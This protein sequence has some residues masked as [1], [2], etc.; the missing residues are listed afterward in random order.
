MQRLIVNKLT[1]L[2]LASIITSI[3]LLEC[4]L[5]VKSLAYSSNSIRFNIYKISAS[6]RWGTCFFR[7]RYLVGVA[8]PL[9]L[10][11]HFQVF[12]FMVTWPYFSTT[13]KNPQGLP[14]GVSFLLPWWNLSAC[15]FT[16]SNPQKAKDFKKTIFNLRKDASTMKVLVVEPRKQPQM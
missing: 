11:T 5:C 15:A 3:F 8:S 10:L 12:L 7:I 14:Y 6:V 2:L 1:T 9:S 16:T 13:A 4:F